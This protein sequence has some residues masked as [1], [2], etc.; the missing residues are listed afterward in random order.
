MHQSERFCWNFTYHLIWNC[1]RFNII[2]PKKIF[3]KSYSYLFRPFVAILRSTGSWM[4]YI[5]IVRCVV[6]LRLVAAP[7]VSARDIDTLKQREAH[8]GQLGSDATLFN[9]VANDKHL[10]KTV[11]DFPFAYFCMQMESQWDNK[12]LLLIQF[13]QLLWYLCLLSV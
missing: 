8:A 12:I 3:V 10:S 6:W 5:S 13:L 11:S 1:I 7:E 2:V 4:L 9:Y